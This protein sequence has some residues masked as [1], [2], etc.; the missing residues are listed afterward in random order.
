MLMFIIHGLLFNTIG[1]NNYAIN[2]AYSIFLLGLMVV[3]VKWSKIVAFSSG[4]IMWIIV[5]ILKNGMNNFLI[6]AQGVIRYGIASAFVVFVLGYV[7]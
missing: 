7:F 3:F 5:Y 6:T 2:L 1:I 4:I